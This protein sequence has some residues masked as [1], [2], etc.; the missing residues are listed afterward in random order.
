M[1]KVVVLGAGG[2]IGGH[3]VRRLLADGFR[4]RAV[5]L[6]PLS[7]WFQVHREA[8]NVRANL[9]SLRQCRVVIQDAQ[10]VFQ[11]AA[12]MGGAQ[13][14][15]SGA[16]DAKII[17]NSALINLNTA[18]AARDYKVERL[19][20]TSSACVYPTAYQLR[21]NAQP[22]SED[23]AYPANP[24][25]DYGFEKLFSERLYFAFHRNYGLSVGVARLFNVYGPRGSWRDG[26]EKAPAALCRKVASV[27]LGRAESVEIIGDG[28]QERSFLYVSDAVEGLI[29]LARCTDSATVNLGSEELVSVSDLVS[30]IEEIAG[31]TVKRLHVAGPLGVERRV[32]DL[33]RARQLLGWNPIVP[34]RV[35]LRELYSWIE[36]Q[37][38]RG[39]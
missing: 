2:F 25:S 22:L 39:G 24:D 5:D 14:V 3:L 37:I 15:F 8:E 32:P 38:Q 10:W 20:F 17:H 13:Y 16:N 26:R 27:K 35:G 6:K 9:L 18:Y 12:D 21:E 28:S 7:A 30:L 11:L 34:L 36:N 1:K 29:R 33:S 23:M 4:V 31:V 19:I